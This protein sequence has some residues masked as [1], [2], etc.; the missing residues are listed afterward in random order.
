[1]VD[2]STVKGFTLSVPQ[3]LFT[4]PF[5]FKLARILNKHLGSIFR[6]SLSR[7]SSTISFYSSHDDSLLYCRDA[8]QSGFVGLNIGSGFFSHPLWGC[9]DLPARSTL[10]KAVQGCIGKDF[11]PLNLNE[12]SLRSHFEGNSFG[13]VYSSHTLEHVSR[14]AHQR[15]FNDV[16][17][18]L[19]PDGVFRICVPD[20]VSIYN[21]ACASKRPFSED[22]FLFLLR[23]AYTPLFM[24]LKDMPPS[25]RKDELLIHYSW[26]KQHSPD[27][28]FAYMANTYNTYSGRQSTFPPDYHISHPT[29]LHLKTVATKAGF[30][31]AYVTS[32]GI[33]STTIFS[34]KYLFD[35]TMPNVSL[36][37]EFVK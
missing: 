9:V 25:K 18:I 6:I 19:K 10:Y 23:E 11:Y 27:E 20:I 17:S 24:L 7:Y 29:E 35:T 31:S 8:A 22:L 26:I 34:N 5:I 28:A 16:Y 3:K 4:S 37:M 1:M 15:I 30:K 13:A 21:A 14:I 12:E 36:Y 33:S 2:D 32:R